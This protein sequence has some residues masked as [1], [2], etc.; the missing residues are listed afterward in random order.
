M[1]DDEDALAFLLALNHACAEK[2]QRGGKITPP[3]LPLPPDEHAAF[4]TEDCIAERAFVTPLIS[5]RG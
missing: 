1:K 4:V 5:K 2:E 3:G